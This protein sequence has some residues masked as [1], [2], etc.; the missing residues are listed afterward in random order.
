MQWPTGDVYS[1]E[2]REGSPQGWG[3]IEWAD[4][5]RYEG[6]F[7]RGLPLGA[8]G[9]LPGIGGGPMPLAPAPAI[10]AGE[11]PGAAPAL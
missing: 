1:G 7:D 4:G 11:P 6:P 2:W 9:A 3:R 5:D 8:I 10:S